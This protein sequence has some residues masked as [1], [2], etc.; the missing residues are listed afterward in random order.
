MRELTVLFDPDCPLCVH[1]RN[2]LATQPKYI[3]M[4]FLSQ[5]SAAANERFPGLN[6]G[7]GRAAEDLIVVSDDGRVWRNTRAWI[8]CFYALRKYRPLAFR[9]SRPS[10]MP[11][12]RRV[13]QAIAAN[14]QSLSRWLIRPQGISDRQLQ[15]AI[16]LDEPDD[17]GCDETHGTACAA[18]R[19]RDAGPDRFEPLT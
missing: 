18:Q 13:Y 7:P 4:R 14:R 10:L 19:R 11:L 1:C 12:A 6:V 17:R 3:P 5:D 16:V 15:R 9:L 2:W 8:I